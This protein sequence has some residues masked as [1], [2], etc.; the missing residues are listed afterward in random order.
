MERFRNVLLE[1]PGHLLHI[2]STTSQRLPLFPSSC[3]HHKLGPSL[4]YSPPLLNSQEQGNYVFIALFVPAGEDIWQSAL[5]GGGGVFSSGGTNRPI[6]T[7]VL[8]APVALAWVL[9]ST[10]RCDMAKLSF[11][12][13]LFCFFI[14]LLI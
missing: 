6:A 11:V 1:A 5:P 4:K 13:V 12:L 14:E 3:T 8:A 10:G 7:M 9:H 2:K